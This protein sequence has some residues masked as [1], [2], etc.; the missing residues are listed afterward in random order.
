[1]AENNNVTQC[2][3]GK[4]TGGRDDAPNQLK[5]HQAGSAHCENMG[6]DRECEG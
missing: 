6:T 2:V 4:I 1:M 5:P 3:I